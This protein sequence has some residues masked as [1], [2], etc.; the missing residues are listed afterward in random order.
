M[1]IAFYYAYPAEWD[2]NDEDLDSA[3]VGGTETALILISRQLARDHRVT[4]F[5]RTRREGKFHGVQYRRLDSF[6][7]EEPW[8]VFIVMRGRA[9]DLKRV[10]APVKIYWSIEEDAVLVKDWSEVLPYV[11]A[12]FTISPFHTAELQRRSGIPPAKIYETRLGVDWEEYAQPLPKEAGKLIYCSVPGR[13][14]PYLASIFPRIREVFPY[15][16]L[17]ITSDYSLWGRPPGTEGYRELFAHLP[18][19]EFLGNVPRP[20]LI[21]EQKTSVL[22]VYPCTVAEL[23]CLAS[24]EC[25]AAGTPTVA[26]ALGALET[27][28]ADGYSGVL[29]RETPG[30]PAFYTRFA[31]A[32][33]TLLGNQTWLEQM[34]RQARTRVQARYTYAH[35]VQEWVE[36]FDRWAQEPSGEERPWDISSQD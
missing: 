25:Q 32:V 21:Q 18:G 2:W 34:A 3:G 5:N 10:K 7:Y 30:Q 17:V 35:I 26:T 1:K 27:T 36:Q 15:A 16:R 13:G 9:P 31:Q 4:V 29:V 22:H 33:L 24:I 23:F 12:V 14:L 11:R 19:V 28:V 20:R 8:D 6:D